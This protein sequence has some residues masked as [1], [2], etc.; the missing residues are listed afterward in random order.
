MRITKEEHDL[1]LKYKANYES[2]ILFI[3][4]N[5]VIFMDYA[6][7]LADRVEKDYPSKT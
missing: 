1:L 5:P 4:H 2:M 7:W 3:L 6:L